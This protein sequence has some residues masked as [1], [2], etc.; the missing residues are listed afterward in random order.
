MSKGSQQMKVRV[1][2]ERQL[3]ALSPNQSIRRVRFRGVSRRLIWGTCLPCLQS[4]QTVKAHI[5][6]NINVTFQKMDQDQIASGVSI[7]RLDEAFQAAYANLMPMLHS[8]SRP[9]Q[10]SLIAPPTLV[11]AFTGTDYRLH[12]RLDQSLVT[13]NRGCARVR[14]RRA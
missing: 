8:C 9:C 5:T 1:V 7:S 2:D 4:K 6:G 3:K 13:F 12:N 14:V 11:R 10:P